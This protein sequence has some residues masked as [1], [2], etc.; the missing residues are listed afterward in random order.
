M[1]LQWLQMIFNPLGTNKKIDL[2]PRSSF[3][4]NYFL[5]DGKLN[6]PKIVKHYQ[7]ALVN[8]CF[9]PLNRV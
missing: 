6:F 9:T 2:F 7:T 8:S 3:A 5:I 1:K 4:H